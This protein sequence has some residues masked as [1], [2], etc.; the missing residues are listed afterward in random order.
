MC[1]H[2]EGI[3]RTLRSLEPQ[4]RTLSTELCSLGFER[5]SGCHARRQEVA[6]RPQAKLRLSQGDKGPLDVQRP[7]KAV[8]PALRLPPLASFPWCPILG[9]GTQS[10]LIR[11]DLSVAV[12]WSQPST[13]VAPS[14]SVTVT[15]PRRPDAH[16]GF[17]LIQWSSLQLHS[18]PCSR[19]GLLCP[20]HS[21][22]SLLPVVHVFSV[23]HTETERWR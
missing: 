5:K 17:T 12:A 9:R 3:A 18:S 7:V 23:C 2:F 10:P 15:C 16:A 6:G 4:G 8:D 19:L 22:T 1:S 13:L 21:V 14:L 20:D 11:T